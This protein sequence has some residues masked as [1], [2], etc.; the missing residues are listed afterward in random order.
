MTRKEQVFDVAIRKMRETGFLGTS[1][2]DIAAELQ[3]E[4]ASLYNYFQSKE[5]ILV[6][7]CFDLAEK[8]Q[9]GLDEVNDIYFNAA[10]KLE[11]AVKN[12]ISIIVEDTN[13]S[14]VFL[15]EWRHLSEEK[16]NTFI[17]LRDKY[18]QGFKQIVEEG[19]SE[20]QFQEIDTKF[21][22]LTI[23]SSLNWVLEWYKPNGTMSAE[24]IAKQL[25]NFVL[26]GLKKERLQ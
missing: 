14:H 8:L 7:T 23:L 12:H 11:K 16:K 5:D 19:K 4:A 15:H 21:A 1:V 6:K 25:Y 3:I 2:R 22:V 17:G 18:E 13:K 20:G 26:L 24:Q 10:E 9:N